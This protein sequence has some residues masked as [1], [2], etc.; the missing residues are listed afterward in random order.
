VARKLSPPRDHK[1]FK[2][3]VISDRTKAGMAAARRRGLH[4]G[5]PPKLAPDQLDDARRMI[6]EGEGTVQVARS[7]GVNPSTLRRLLMKG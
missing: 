2:R 7:L 6:V 5:H 1:G 4:V 3:N